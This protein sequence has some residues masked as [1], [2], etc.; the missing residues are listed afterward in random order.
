MREEDFPDLETVYLDSACMSRRP[1]RVIEKIEEYYTDYPACPG[2][3]N[4][5]LAGRAGEE[6]ESAREKIA[7]FIDARPEDLVL[8]SGTTES[9][10]IVA[11]GFTAENVFISDRE[12]NSNLVPW[13]QSTKNLSIISTENGFDLERLDHE[14]EEGDLV[15]IVHVSNLD[16]YELPVKEIIEIARENGAYTL[17]D[18]AQSIPHQEFS[19]KNLEPDFVAFSGHKMLGPSGTGGLYVSDRVKDELQPLVEGGGGVRN[20]TYTESEP[21]DFPYNMEAGLPNLAGFIGLGEAVEYLESVGME[22]IEDH[23]KKLTASLRSGLEDIDNVKTVGRDG[24]GVVSFRIEGVDPHQVSLM[25]NQKDIAV[26]SGMHCLHSWFNDRREKP[27]VRV[28]LHLYNTESD[29]ERFLDAVRNIS[30]LS[31]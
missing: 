19:V 15:S 1:K 20:S 3:S 17:I 6:L 24:N 30:M 5:S 27:S 10:N 13:Q 31:G 9:I 28:S 25:L 7:S 11:N 16:G 18:A 14:I 23:E 26:R 2:R 29:V 12:H 4:H 8:T 21:R 22:K